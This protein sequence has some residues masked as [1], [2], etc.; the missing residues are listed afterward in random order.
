V[1]STSPITS[2]ANTAAVA[3]S[4]LPVVAAV[5]SAAVVETHPRDADAALVAERQSVAQLQTLLVA[6]ET[7]QLDRLKL[8][9]LEEAE[10]AR[11]ADVQAQPQHDA[12]TR[13]ELAAWRARKVAS[14]AAE[15]EVANEMGHCV[16]GLRDEIA[17]GTAATTASP[18]AS[19]DERV[20]APINRFDAAA[21]RRSL[22]ADAAVPATLATILR[23]TNPA[24]TPV[25]KGLSVTPGATVAQISASLRVKSNEEIASAAGTT[26]AVTGSSLVDATS[27]VVTTVAGFVFSDDSKTTRDALASA[28]DAVWASIKALRTAVTAAAKAYQANEPSQSEGELSVARVVAGI[29]G[30]YASS[31]FQEAVGILGTNAQ[32]SAVQAAKAATSAADQ[33]STSLG[34]SPKYLGAYK[35]RCWG[36]GAFLSP[37]F[38]TPRLFPPPCLSQVLS[39]SLLTLLAILG[40]AA[41]RA[42]EQMK[43]DK[44]LPSSIDK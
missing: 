21:A 36:A 42:A 35:V 24:A 30:V 20:L 32:K 17:A 34:Q 33:L 2:S 22:T 27:A 9:S 43:A 5:P 8:V 11:I 4:P 28:T 29:K 16:A 12:G 7:S 6:F 1:V 39:E 13:E 44:Q 10:V 25:F 18:G 15:R 19:R 14:I 41:S 40:A 31:E 23:R 38:T 3:S 26:L 37:P